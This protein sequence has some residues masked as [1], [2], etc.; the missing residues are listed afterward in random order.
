MQTQ[1]KWKYYLLQNTAYA[2]KLIKL[3][4]L[5]NV[6]PFSEW[7]ENHVITKNL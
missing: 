6:A 4:W 1:L 7:F 3:V 5:I 2:F